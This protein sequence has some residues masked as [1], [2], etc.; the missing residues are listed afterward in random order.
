VSS[1]TVQIA[2]ADVS[3][4]ESELRGARAGY[5]PNLDLELGAAAGDNLDG[6]EG[7]DVSAQALV[8]LRYNLFRGG[9]DIAREREAFLRIKEARQSLRVAQRD[10]EQE[11]RVA[12]NALLTA[13][14]RLEAL[15][16][17]VEAQRATRDIY[18]QQFD[19]GQRGLLDLLDAEN[20]LFIDRTNLVT[21][22][23][24]ETF[25]VYRVLAV[26]GMLLDT[27][28]IERPKEAINIYREGERPV[29][30]TVPIDARE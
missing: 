19:L 15:R 2:N 3:V 10:A 24:T 6:L 29:Y 12:Y 23:F 11:A 28:D 1:P 17:G 5:Y 16:D 9:A 4:A 7:R 20:E 22:T 30:G 18:A 13:R 14:A 8:V 27:L 21:A 26:I 25:A